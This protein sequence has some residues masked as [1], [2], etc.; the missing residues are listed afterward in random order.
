MD[1]FL[2]VG[3]LYHVAGSLSS[4][5]NSNSSL[6]GVGVLGKDMA[7]G[8]GLISCIALGKGIDQLVLDTIT[9]GGITGSMSL[10]D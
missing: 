7:K 3:H 8:D 5:V 6:S 1:F 9:G 4:E 2:S 10:V